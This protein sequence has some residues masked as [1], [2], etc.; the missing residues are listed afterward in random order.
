MVDVLVVTWRRDVLW[1]WDSEAVV[2]ASYHHDGRWSWNSDVFAD[3]VS[4]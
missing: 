2:V 1:S 4:G 3:C